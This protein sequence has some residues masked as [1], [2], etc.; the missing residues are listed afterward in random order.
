MTVKLN[1]TSR[2]LGMMQNDVQE[3]NFRMLQLETI[4]RSA[5]FPCSESTLLRAEIRSLEIDIQNIT[6]Q[7]L[8]RNIE[9]KAHPAN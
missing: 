1:L 3:M 9:P 7:N 4:G 2:V 5:P 8:P 6:N